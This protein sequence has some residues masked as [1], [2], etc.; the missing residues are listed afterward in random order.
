MI[1]IQA[2]MFKLAFIKKDIKARLALHIGLVSVI[3][4]TLRLTKTYRLFVFTK[5]NTV[6][7]I[8]LIK[9]ISSFLF[10][11]DWI[12]YQTYFLSGNGQSHSRRTFLVQGYSPPSVQFTHHTSIGRLVTVYGHILVNSRDHKWS[13]FTVL[14]AKEQ[15][16]L[17][18]IFSLMKVS[19]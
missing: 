7:N 18:W 1:I 13:Y 6:L 2:E 14:T 16:K 15:A 3:W 5:L 17:E 10:S 19:L 4:V 8:F 11:K 12:H 9:H